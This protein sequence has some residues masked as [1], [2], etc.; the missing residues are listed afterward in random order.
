MK[1]AEASKA[2]GLAP[3]FVRDIFEGRK[4]SL[5]GDTGGALA[6]VLGTTL[7]WLVE[8]RGAETPGGS[9][10]GLEFVASK[11]LPVRGTVA[12]GIWA[13]AWDE[14]DHLA[15]EDIEHVQITPPPGY[16]R[17]DLFALRVK[18]RSMDRDYLDGDILICCP[19]SETDP[20]EH[21]HVIAIRRRHNLV[22]ATV[23]E[24]LQLGR[25]R[26]ALQARSSD[27]QFADPWPIND[28]GDETPEIIGVVVGS[29]RN[30]V[31]PAVLLPPRRNGKKGGVN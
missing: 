29:Y 23:K 19:V 15:P 7:E 2:A 11:A 1:P 9:A 8:G 28:D 20:R 12:A 26:W 16:E 30:R 13:E 25:G 5:R 22:E 3:T 27:P 4:K 17:T 31:R 24:L 14:T 6:E 18:G 10:P 21:D